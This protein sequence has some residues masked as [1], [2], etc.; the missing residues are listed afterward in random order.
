MASPEFDGLGHID[1]TVT[2][3]ERSVQWWTEVMGFTVLAAAWER[4]SFRGWTMVHPS[5]VAVTLLLHDHGDTAAFDE[6]RVG[7]DHLA[8]HVRDPSALEVWAAHLDAL[9]VEHSGI[10]DHERTTGG[11]LIVL[12]DPDN[13]QLELTAGWQPTP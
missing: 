10:Q 2:D 5:G 1:L 9:G 13:I 11:P 7:L 8:F 12:R 4:P 6:R 3:A